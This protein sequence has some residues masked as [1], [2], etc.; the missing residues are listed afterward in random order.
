MDKI[1]PCPNC[2]KRNRVPSAANGVPRC[3]ACHTPLPW[4]TVAGD[5]DY[6]EVITQPAA[7]RL[8][9]GVELF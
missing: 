5:G 7:R 2:G 3:A 8:L 4:L 9:A 1:I 6:E